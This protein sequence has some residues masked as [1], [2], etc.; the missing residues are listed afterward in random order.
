MGKDYTLR[1]TTSLP[2][3][4]QATVGLCTTIQGTE[5]KRHKRHK[6]EFKLEV[7]LLV[8]CLLCSFLV[9]LVLRSRF[10]VQSRLAQYWETTGAT[11]V[12][13]LSMRCAMK[14]L[15]ELKPVKH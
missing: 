9:L 8:L 13:H 11:V 15:L 6:K 10:V 3:F 5:H 7:L 1:F 12:F 4:S 14:N 2:L